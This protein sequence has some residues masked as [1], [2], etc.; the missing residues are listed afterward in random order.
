MIVEDSRDDTPNEHGIVWKAG[1]KI[2]ETRS[3][4]KERL[5]EPKHWIINKHF[6]LQDVRD[7]NGFGLDLE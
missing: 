5:T 3:E 6:T 4:K 7:R 1:A 2:K